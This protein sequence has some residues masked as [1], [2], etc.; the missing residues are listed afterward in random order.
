MVGRYGGVGS[1]EF[2]LY[3]PQ[4]WRTAPHEDVVFE[5]VCGE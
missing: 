5:E 4:S 2:V 3:W 1:D